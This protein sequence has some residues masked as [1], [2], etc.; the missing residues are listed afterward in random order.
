VKG[1][2]LMD[3]NWI[4]EAIKKAGND[5]NKIGEPDCYKP[6]NDPYP[7]CIGG[8]EHCKHCCLYEDMEEPIM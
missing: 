6:N 1:E 5:F 8:Y 7:L 2:I 4:E 3:K